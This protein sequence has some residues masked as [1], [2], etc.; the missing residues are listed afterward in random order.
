[1]IRL[2]VTGIN[3][4]MGQALI[5][6]LY[7]DLFHDLRLSAALDSSMA[8]NAENVLQAVDVILDFTNA[9]SAI[10]YAR[11]CEKLRKPIIIGSTGFDDK[12]F[13]ELAQI[14]QRNV[15]FVSANMSWGVAVL[16]YLVRLAAGK[17]DAGEFDC[18]IL[19]VHHRHK[20]DAPSGTALMLGRSVA[21]VHE[22]A[23]NEVMKLDAN[24]AKSLGQIGFASLRGGGV[25]GDHTVSFSS[26]DEVISIGHRALNRMVFARGAL[27]VVRWVMQANLQPGR[28][29]SM[30][31]VVGGGHQI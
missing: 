3:G 10:N 4:R 31:D 16:N 27:K 28:I 5:Q 2:A 18:D 19:E 20:Q 9:E 25:F 23:L 30:D 22:A 1:M 29:Y 17:F 15:V 26:T 13:Q 7:E 14:A 8:E 24:G 11:L 6:V 21:Q 12:Q